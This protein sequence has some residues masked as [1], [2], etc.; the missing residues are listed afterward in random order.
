LTQLCLLGSIS[1]IPYVFYY[2]NFGVF[3]LITQDGYIDK[4]LIGLER[5]YSALFD[6][7]QGIIVG[8]PGIIV[9]GMF[10][11]LIRAFN[12]LSSKKRFCFDLSD[13]LVLV[14][15]VILL[16]TLGQVNWNSGHEVFMRYGFW[17]SMPLLVWLAVNVTQLGKVPQ[18]FILGVILLL[19]LIPHTLFLFRSQW[20]IGYNSMMPYIG[21]VFKHLPDLYNPE[22]EIF[23]E[24]VLGTEVIEGEEVFQ[25]KY[26]PFVYRKDGEILKVLLAKSSL[27]SE[28]IKKICGH[29]GQ[30]IFTQTGQ[31][32]DLSKVKFNRLGHRQKDGRE[33]G[34]LSQSIYCSYTLPI[35]INFASSGNASPFVGQGWSLPESWGRRTDATVAEIFIP[36]IQGEKKDIILTAIVNGFVNEQ[37]PQQNVD[38]VIN[39]KFIERWTFNHKD[40]I[41]ER[42]IKI[43]SELINAKFPTKITFK[44]QSA[45]SPAQLNLSSDGRSLGM[46]LQKVRLEI[47]R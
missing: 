16:P 41:S 3:S 35:T 36:P 42:K 47:I 31:K 46:G 44:L 22:P 15:F 19:Q 20:N 32:V 14:F 43:S 18:S 45:I 40:E 12:A 29:K 4:N 8:F 2:Y 28:T 6:L 5:V 21:W 24:R 1:L 26:A 34:Y 9:G 37:H 25:P 7:N 39:N 10:I 11:I 23:A 13:W 33:W 27:A 38:I 17:T 30:P